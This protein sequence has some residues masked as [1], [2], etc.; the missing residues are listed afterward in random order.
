MKRGISVKKTLFL[1]LGAMVT[2]STS[3][4]RTQLGPDK[5]WFEHS[6][7]QAPCWNTLEPGVTDQANA[8]AFLENSPLISINSIQ[9]RGEPWNEFDDIVFFDLAQ[10]EI[11]A[12]MGFMNGRIST[13]R[14]FRFREPNQPAE[15]LGITIEDVFSRYG[16]PTFVVIVDDLGPAGLLF[17]NIHTFV[18]LLNPLTGIA[19][20]YDRESLPADDQKA[21]SE[22]ILID[23]LIYF[24]P[25]DYSRLM[26]M[27]F[28]N[29]HIQ[30]DEEFIDWQ[31]YGEYFPLNN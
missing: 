20:R 23:H 29:M 2:F 24:F 22:G 17:E 5:S 15:P 18:F 3:C 4:T 14:F 6:S 7:C 27:G 19:V 16:D 9:S 25:G 12:E 28:L 13:I 31:G 10:A 21:I 1:L 11:R 30:T 8:I 26:S